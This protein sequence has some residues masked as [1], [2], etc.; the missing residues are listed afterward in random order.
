MLQFNINDY[1]GDNVCMHCAT[2]DEANTFLAFLDSIGKTWCNGQSYLDYPRYDDYGEDTC[3]FFNEGT[4]DSLQYAR[5]A[6]WQVLDFA[7]FE[8]FLIEEEFVTD[9]RPLDDFF[10]A[11]PLCS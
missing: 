1:Q 10:S 3:Y 8:F 5:D 9:E 2:E 7:D 6:G 11:F 4:Y